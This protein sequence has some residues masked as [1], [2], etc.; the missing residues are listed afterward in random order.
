MVKTVVLCQNFA[1]SI[2]AFAFLFKQPLNG[3]KSV[4][5]MR[6]ALEIAR[7]FK[8]IKTGSTTNLN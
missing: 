3:Q 7:K 4:W 6:L 1:G 2:L 5:P 8:D